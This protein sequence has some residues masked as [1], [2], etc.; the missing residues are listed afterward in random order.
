MHVTN[1]RQKL[2]LNV[3][4][5]QCN[6]LSVCKYRAGYCQEFSFGTVF[7]FA[8][9]CL[10]V[11]LTKYSYCTRNALIDRHNGLY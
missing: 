7:H 6:A 1:V 10:P 8:A 9:N 3:K 5:Y 4:M 2:C 11:E